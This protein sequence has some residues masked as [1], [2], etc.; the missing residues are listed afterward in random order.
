[1]GELTG[2]P[3]IAL[4]ALVARR[5]AAAEEVVAAHPHRI[6]AVNDLVNAVVVIDRERAPADAREADAAY[7]R[8]EP[9]GH[10]TASHSR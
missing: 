5:E 3:A 2:L 8:G 7:A 6:D 9:R 10:C 4:A 1:M